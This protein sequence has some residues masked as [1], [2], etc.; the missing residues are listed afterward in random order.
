MDSLTNL[1]REFL[2][3]LEAFLHDREYRL[4]DSFADWPELFRMSQQHHMTAAVYEKIR[5]NPIAQ[6]P[7]TSQLFMAWK[8]SAIRD[9]MLQ[10]Q[11]TDGFLEIYG[12]L[13]DAGVTPL[14]VKGLI[15][16]ELYAKPD[17]RIS[18]D[19]D[20]L[21]PKEEFSNCDRI[22]LQE[23]FER[24][25]VDVKHLPYEIAY[26]NRKN[27]VYIEL[28]F[29]LFPEESGAYGHLNDEFQDVFAHRICVS[30]KGHQVWTLC[31]TEH[32]FYL[33]CHSFKHFLHSGFGM[34]QVCDM[35]LMA[36]AYG[37][38]VAW[39][40][41]E[42]RLCR[43][44]MK[45]YWDA[46][47]KIGVQY[48]GFSLEKASY[49]SFAAY[50]EIEIEPLLLDLLDSGIYGASTME[51]KHS[52][53]MTLAAVAE[54]KANTGASLWASIFPGRNYMKTQFVWLNRYP[55]MLPIAYGMRLV[56]Y[57]KSSRKGGDEKNSVQIGKGRL[58]LLK[59]YH[60]I[61]G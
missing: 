2:K 44:N 49:E 30:V 19:E 1:Q 3:I 57:L 58:E 29:S 15:C 5:Q 21:V 60:I 28:H 35:V 24:Q 16:R 23:G 32:L 42:E 33:I 10:M 25:E 9:V 54:G 39:R 7:Q 43:L 8:R 56:R 48:L 38:S 53:N 18:G 14:V 40:D 51:R 17:Y 37:E 11:R 36:E 59:T 22:L 12:K 4:S 55:W 50:A 41:I 6:D 13:V 46:L 27:G 61:D 34:R 52:S 31:A 20:I 47:V 45:V 26:L